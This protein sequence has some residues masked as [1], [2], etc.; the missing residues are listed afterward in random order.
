MF[1]RFNNWTIEDFTKLHDKAYPHSSKATKTSFI[2]TLKRIEAIYETPLNELNNEH[3]LDAKKL[4]DRLKESKYTDNTLTTT[5]TSVLKLL[6]M[7]DS[8]LSHYNDY[9]KVLGKHTKQLIEQKRNFVA[10][11]DLPTWTELQN[12][13][14]DYV[15]KD[16][17]NEQRNYLLLGFFMLLPPVRISNYTR[18]KLLFDEDVPNDSNNYLMKNKKGIFVIFNK[19]RTSHIQGQRIMEIKDEFLK[20]YITAYIEQY[21]LQQGNYFLPKNFYLVHKALNQN[22]LNEILY[23]ETFKIFGSSYTTQDL[24]TMFLREIFNED[25]TIREKIEIADIMG[26]KDYKNIFV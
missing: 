23:T 18:F 15:P 14:L 25:P 19:Y 6:K 21:N 8:P 1:E 24:R 16:D 10:S 5:F 3:L 2:Q 12:K 13:Y 4:Y 11:Q 22:E 17:F 26:Y 9:V 7:L 20:Q